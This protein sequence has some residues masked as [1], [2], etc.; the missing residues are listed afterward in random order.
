MGSICW[1]ER[2]SAEDSAIIMADYYG[3]YKH[4]IC[5]SYWYIHT[6]IVNG[7]VDAEERNMGEDKKGKILG[8]TA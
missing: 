1:S 5:E 6:A 7:W 2:F 4:L 3:I 8:C